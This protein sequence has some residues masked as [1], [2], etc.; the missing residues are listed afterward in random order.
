MH[1]AA[2][3]T[4]QLVYGNKEQ[5]SAGII[6]AGW[7]KYSGGQVFSIPLGGGVVKQ[8]YAIGGSGST[9]IYGYCDSTFKDGMTKE[10]C[11][12]FVKNSIALAM[13]RDGSSGGTIRLAVI[14]K[15]NVERIFVP[16]DKL[17]VFYEG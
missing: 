7:D 6:V 14:T 1:T 16:G 12:D 15:D 3:I 5:L 11:I 10:Q 13:S 4:N 2:S 17:P 9:F 8:A